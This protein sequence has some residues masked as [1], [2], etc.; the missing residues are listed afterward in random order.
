MTARPKPAARLARA[1]SI[2]LVAICA[3]A[4]GAFAQ[5]TLL[6]P[7]GAERVEPAPHY[8]VEDGLFALRPGQTIDLTDRNILLAFSG[9]GSQRRARAANSQRP[10]RA[11]VRINGSRRSMSVGDRINLLRERRLAASLEGKARCYLDLTNLRV[12]RGA[13]PQAT[14]RL[15]CI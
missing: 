8:R 5:Q 14:F 6:A 1:L 12:A 3:M 11:E 9:V 15:N 4:G 13:P 10:E 2:T 7:P